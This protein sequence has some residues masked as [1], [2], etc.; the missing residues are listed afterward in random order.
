[1]KQARIL[2]DPKDEGGF[3]SKRNAILRRR[4][5]RF[6]KNG[7]AEV[8][9]LIHPFHI[10]SLR[11][12][13]RRVL[14]KGGMRLGDSLS[15]ERYVAYDEVVFSFFHRQLTGLVSDLVGT[16]VKPT[17]VYTICY[18]AG[19]DL[20]R[21]KDRAQCQYTVTL[22]LDCAPD[23]R[24]KSPW[25]LFLETTKGAVEIRQRV[26]ESL[27]YRSTEIPHSRTP[28]PDGMTSTSVLFHYVG[29]DFTGPL[30]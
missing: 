3:F 27:L 11:H 29:Q 18:Q 9:Q 16:P 25:P 30:K 17:Y 21:H 6:H 10:G 4:Q 5:A 13:S 2:V 23:L 12:Y 22:L 28:I 8:G 7:Y 26:G 14:R 15:P 19:S 24:G 20:P 1:M